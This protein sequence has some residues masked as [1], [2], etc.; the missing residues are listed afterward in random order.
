MSTQRIHHTNQSR[1]TVHIN[2]QN[3][4]DCGTF[5]SRAPTYTHH[6][7]VLF[8]YAQ[9]IT[10]ICNTISSLFAYISHVKRIQSFL[11]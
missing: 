9:Y 11:I 1:L 3:G 2:N 4:I 8:F 7:A 10:I 6:H 5:V